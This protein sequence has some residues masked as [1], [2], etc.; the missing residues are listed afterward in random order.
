PRESLKS[1]LEELLGRDFVFIKCG[2]EDRT[3]QYR[4]Q[5]TDGANI[6]AL[7]PGIVVGYERNTNT[8][9]ALQDRGYEI[10]NQHQFI[11]K[12]TNKPIQS[13]AHKIAVSFEGNEL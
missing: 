6:F 11:R 2:G 5:W 1:V 8:F 10:M 13:S 12:Y 4:E 9:K 7:A 3:M